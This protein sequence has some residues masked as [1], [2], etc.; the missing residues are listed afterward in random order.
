MEESEAIDSSKSRVKLV[1]S[2]GDITLQQRNSPSSR[3]QKKDQLHGYFESAQWYARRSSYPAPPSLTRGQV[4]NIPT[5]PKTIDRTADGTTILTTSSN[6]QIDGYIL[7]P[8]LLDPESSP[9][10]LN[11]QVTIPLSERTNVLCP[12]PYFQLAEAYTNQILI[13]S[14][15]LPIQ[16][17][18]L[19]PPQTS[20]DGTATKVKHQPASSYPFMRAHSETF[21]SA[22]AMLWP[23]PG[24][25]FVAATKNLLAKFDVSRTGEEPLLRIKTIP[26][27][28]HLSKGS[29]VGMR[30]TISTLAAHPSSSESGL[31]LVA[32]GTWTRWVGMYDF[33]QA[34]DCVAAW[35]IESAVQKTTERGR[36]SGIGI[37]GNGVTQTAWSPCGRYLLVSERKSRGVLVYDVRVTGE[38][39]GWLEGRDA[40]DSNQ[41]VTCDV[42]LSGDAAGGGFEVWSGTTDGTVKVWENVGMREGPHAPAWDW[43]GHE[44]TVGSTCLHPSGSVIATCSGAWDF[45]GQDKEADSDNDTTK[46]R[47]G[48]QGETERLPAWMRRSNKESS[49]KIWCLNSTDGDTEAE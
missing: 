1:A 9:H 12:A 19:Y 31:G 11:P 25:H 26:S 32:A 18:Y 45:A 41:R 48:D 14:H 7:P 44:S 28:R 8:D 33:A 5:D 15:D 36:N 35:G 10:S 20:E 21:L 27:E 16:L 47:N 38:L 13:S 4:L 40:A 49:L 34:G 46:S 6:H 39:L 23:S 29:G 2:T 3:P 30:G 42:F 37:G 24:T 22:T 17:Y 43:Q